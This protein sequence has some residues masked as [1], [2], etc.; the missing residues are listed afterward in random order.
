MGNSV[1]EIFGT[2]VADGDRRVMKSASPNFD[3]PLCVFL[4]KMDDSD[5]LARAA[6][7]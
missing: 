7:R 6:R 3:T 5:M 1:N 4:G 2:A